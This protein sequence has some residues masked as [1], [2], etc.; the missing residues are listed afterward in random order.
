MMKDKL[1]ESG[2]HLHPPFL[3][4]PHSFLLVCFYGSRVK[5]KK[6][7]LLIYIGADGDHEKCVCVLECVGKMSSVGM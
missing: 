2:P 7:E 1:N 5:R 6:Q 3:L 4:L